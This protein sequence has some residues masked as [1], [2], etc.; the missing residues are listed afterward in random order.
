MT[1]Q[2]AY[3][4]LIKYLK[5]PVLLK[6]SLA[7]EAA[8]R[9]LA[10]YFGEDVETWGITGLLHDA[11]YDKS[12]GNPDKHGLLLSKLEPNSI[13]G[14]VEHAINAHNF[15]FTHIQPNSKLDWALLICDELTAI[16]YDFAIREHKNLKEL[17]SEIILSKLNDPNAFKGAKKENV[18]LC[19]EKLGIS[20]EKLISNV[21]SS[22]QAIAHELNL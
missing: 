9:S 21:L 17:T 10:P 22:M 11:D 16:I 2:T 19:N 15:E 3:Q 20:L 6:H 12:K 7:T 14:T 8:M 13:P 4:I 18:F 1:R 5:N